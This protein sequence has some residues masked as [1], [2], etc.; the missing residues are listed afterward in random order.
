MPDTDNLMGDESGQ[1]T[2]AGLGTPTGEVSTGVDYNIKDV[3]QTNATKQPYLN[4]DYSHENRSAKF[5][6]GEGGPAF[7][8]GQYGNDQYYGK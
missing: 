1:S 5:K 8:P 4:I 6:N 7:E 3:N 2:T